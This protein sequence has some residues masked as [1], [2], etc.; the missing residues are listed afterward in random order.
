MS[1]MPPPFGSSRTFP[2]ALT[3]FG[4]LATMAFAPL[5]ACDSPTTTPLSTLGVLEVTTLT[6]G[7]EMLPDSFE[8]LVNGSRSGTTG[9]NDVYYM[10]ALPQGSY[11]VGLREDPEDCRFIA[12]PRE[13]LVTAND[14]AYTTFLVICR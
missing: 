5:V 9:P 6:E 8:V 4:T 3:S 14:T 12:N 10:E 7:Q 13:L 11:Q 2:R 1:T